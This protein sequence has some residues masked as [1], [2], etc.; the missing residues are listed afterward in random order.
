MTQCFI[1]EPVET[2]SQITAFAN[3]AT[4]QHLEIVDYDDHHVTF[5]AYYVLEDSQEL[6]H[7]KSLFTCKDGK[8]CYESG[9][10]Y[11]SKIEIKRNDVCICQSGKKYK[12]CCG[13]KIR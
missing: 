13:Q 7:E 8:W 9:K 3:A 5:K 1:E 4:F 6:L 2:R 10:L 11:A 12:K